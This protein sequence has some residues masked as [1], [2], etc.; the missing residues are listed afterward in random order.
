MILDVES[1][2]VFTS[3]CCKAVQYIRH[4]EGKPEQ[5][6]PLITR[7]L[8]KMFVHTCSGE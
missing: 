6:H 4:R 7:M 5:V 3:V 2:T 1:G 8:R